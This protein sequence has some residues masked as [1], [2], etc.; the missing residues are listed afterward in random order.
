MNVI[1]EIF[2][3]S[4]IDPIIW[5]IT[6]FVTLVNLQSQ[7]HNNALKE[8]LFQSMDIG[9]TSIGWSIAHRTLDIIV[10]LE[11][12]NYKSKMFTS[13]TARI[14]VWDDPSFLG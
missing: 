4:S 9:L 7:T 8:C 6:N 3:S 1:F 12:K 11:K 13:R 14:Q 10:I 2:F 5:N